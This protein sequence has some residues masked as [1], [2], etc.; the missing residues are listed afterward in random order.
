MEVF[1]S[2]LRGINVSGHNKIL[3][4]ELKELYGELGFL[5]IV[6]YIQSGNV[7]FKAGKSLSHQD[8]EEMITAKILGK[9]TFN[10]PVLVRTAGEMQKILAANP[11]LEQKGMDIS[12][13]HVTFLSG[14]PA[15][16][17]V[18]ALEKLDHSPDEFRVAGREVY[19]HIPG[20]Y[21]NTKLSNTF[22][23]NKLK[24]RASTR[25]WKTITTLVGLATGQ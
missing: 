23:E 21:G 9:Y 15:R 13:L 14:K 10:V 8:I 7:I 22:F 5:D 16:P 2:I 25:N 19:L 4:A 24:V 3:M 6:T 12:K 18:Q 17:A 11:F 1:I 20:G